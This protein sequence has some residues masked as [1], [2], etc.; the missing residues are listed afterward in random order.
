MKSAMTNDIGNANV[1][2]MLSLWVTPDMWDDKELYI[3]IT[4]VIKKLSDASIHLTE[5]EL[6]LIKELTSGL[7]DA[8]LSALEKADE[9]LKKDFALSIKDILG[10][11]SFLDADEYTH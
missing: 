11:Q 10:F 4:E 6:Y 5:R 9:M 8:T 3:E 7:L 2:N 1:I